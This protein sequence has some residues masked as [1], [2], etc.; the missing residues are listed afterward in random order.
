[1]NKLLLLISICITILWYKNANCKKCKLEAFL[2]GILLL[3]FN[4]NEIL[5]FRLFVI[6]IF[7]E[8]MIKLIHKK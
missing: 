5:L 4:G 6:F 7:G 3:Q 2:I 1:M 8:M